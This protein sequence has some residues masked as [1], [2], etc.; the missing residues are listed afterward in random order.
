[1][2]GPWGKCRH[3]VHRS[4]FSETVNDSFKKCH[5]VLQGSLDAQLHAQFSRVKISSFETF[6]GGGLNLNFVEF[7]AVGYKRDFFSAAYTEYFQILSE[8]QSDLL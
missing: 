8:S 3:G 2:G 4:S 7:Q 1:M 6:L 5:R